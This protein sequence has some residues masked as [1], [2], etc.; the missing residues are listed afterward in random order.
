MSIMFSIDNRTG[1]I[2][3]FFTIVCILRSYITLRILRLY[4]DS[5]KNQFLSIRI[6]NALP[7]NC[8]RGDWF[9]RQKQGRRAD[10]HKTNLTLC[11]LRMSI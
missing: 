8:N 5:N 9:H 3:K 1:P 4:L 10:K 11:C 7:A 6:E 2:V